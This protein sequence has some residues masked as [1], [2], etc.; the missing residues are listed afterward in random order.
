MGHQRRREHG[1]PLHGVYQLRWSEPDASDEHDGWDRL[2]EPVQ[3]FDS[4]GQLQIICAGCGQAYPREPDHRR[5][6]L[7]PSVRRRHRLVNAS[8]QRFPVNS[9]HSGR[10]VRKPYR[11]RQAAIRLLQPRDLALLQWSAQ[12]FQLRLL[13]RHHYSRQWHRHFH[14]YHFLRGRCRA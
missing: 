3:L 4:G 7:Q 5:D 6:Q 14:S 9:D 2:V 12:R 11:H 8:L 13:A 10:Q 1:R